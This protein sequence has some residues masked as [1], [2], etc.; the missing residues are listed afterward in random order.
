MDRDVDLRAVPS[1]SLIHGV[2]DHLI[3][4]VVEPRFSRRPDI[5]RGTLPNRL[6]TFQHLD[7]AGIVLFRRVRRRYFVCH[8]ILIV[9]TCHEADHLCLPQA[10]L[11]PGGSP[12]SNKKAFF[13]RCLTRPKASRRAPLLLTNDG[14]PYLSWTSVTRRERLLIIKSASASQCTCIALPDPPLRA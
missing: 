4:Q 13:F 12:F 11:S 1:Q 2:V 8:R 5:H 14:S 3:N 6:E 10:S 7:R 9:F